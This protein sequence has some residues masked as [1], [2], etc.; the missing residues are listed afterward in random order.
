MR[1]A[2][3]S[4]AVAALAAGI[5]LTWAAASAA[6]GV[7]ARDLQA[8]APGIDPVVVE[9]GLAAA[10]CAAPGS[11]TP[12]R[13]LVLIDYSRPSTQPRLWVLDLPS[14][15]LLHEELV[16]HGRGSGDNLSSLFSNIPGSHQSSLGL[17][18][19]AETY[20]G[21][22]GYSLRLDGLEPGINQRAREREIV[23]HAAWYVSDG[24]AASLGRLGRSWGCPAVRPEISR[25][26]ID[27]IKDGNYLFAY[28]PDARWLNASSALTCDA[29]KAALRRVAAHLMAKSADR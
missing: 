22:H 6:D 3:V 15:K 13:R 21:G 7:L 23:M 11:A 14:R 8:A 9:L 1:R 16:A 12:G 27:D 25:Q 4:R 28:Y 18:R 2:I 26:L 5:S 29:G 10:Q 17:F 20:V 19:T 24:T